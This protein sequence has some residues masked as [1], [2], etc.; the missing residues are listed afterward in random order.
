MFLCQLS[1]HQLPLFWCL[2]TDLLT[3]RFEHLPPLTQ[4]LSPLVSIK[5]NASETDPTKS[6]VI[7]LHVG[8]QDCFNAMK[9][10]T[11][12]NLQLNL[13]PVTCRVLF[14]SLVM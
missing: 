12:T 6:D 13:P 11:F 3:A 2:T 5:A 14:F 9:H 7:N 10:Q 1:I 4:A 8:Y